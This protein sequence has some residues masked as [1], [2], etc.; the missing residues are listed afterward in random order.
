MSN[1]KDWDCV[2]VFDPAD[3]EQETFNQ[4]SD[5][6]ISNHSAVG[7][8]YVPNAEQTRKMLSEY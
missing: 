4:F 6:L 7:D 2:M 1:V 8:K 5:Y 3:T